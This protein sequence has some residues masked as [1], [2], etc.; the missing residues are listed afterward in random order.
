MAPRR[1]PNRP[2][3]IVDVYCGFIPAD[4]WPFG[5]PFVLELEI[6]RGSYIVSRVDISEDLPG[7]GRHLRDNLTGLAVSR[8][9]AVWSSEQT[10]RYDAPFWR[11]VEAAVV[12]AV[13]AFKERHPDSYVASLRDGVARGGI[14]MDAA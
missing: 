7:L 10:G 6:E 14:T 8:L 3:P 9:V 12:F 5:R 1:V 13:K 4:V 2:A 11:W